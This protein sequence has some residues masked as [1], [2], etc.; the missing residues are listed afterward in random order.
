MWFCLEFHLLIDRKPCPSPIRLP[1]VSQ[2]HSKSHTLPMVESWLNHLR[3]LRQAYQ[4][5][6]VALKN[7]FYKFDRTPQ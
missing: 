7:R 1:I 5:D 2:T 3:D 6:D 4:A